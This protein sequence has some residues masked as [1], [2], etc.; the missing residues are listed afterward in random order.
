MDKHLF[1][2]CQEAIFI[3]RE[4][5]AQFKNPAMLWSGGKDSTAM[6]SLCREAFFNTVPFPVIHIDNGA[7]FPETYQFLDRLAQEWNLKLLTAK[8]V[9]KNDS[10][11]G[12]SCCGANKTAA[13]KKL[14]KKRKFD[15]LIVSIRS[16]EHGIRAKERVFSPRNKNW[17]WN[18]KNQ[19]AE[20][21]SF[22]SI[23]GGAE[24]HRIH[25]LLHWREMDTWQYIFE[26]DIPVNSLYFARSGKRFRSL[27]CGRCTVPIKSGAKNV[28]DILKELG[29]TEISERAGRIQD[30]E[31]QAVM[32]RLRVLGYM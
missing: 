25:P 3:L 14:M 23:A 7:D 32:E 11:S 6:L 31:A 24:H 21:W 27:G 20:V 5:K 15:G 13:L 17:R 30:K 2:L 4:A 9:I 26:N 12:L 10:I 16:D 1:Q 8:S 19:P 29:D 18:Y 28:V 22:A